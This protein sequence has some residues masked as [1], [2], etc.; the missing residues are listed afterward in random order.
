LGIGW[1]MIWEL[2]KLIQKLKELEVNTMG[3]FRKLCGTP[4]SKK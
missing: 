4:K 3:T 1:G 2:W